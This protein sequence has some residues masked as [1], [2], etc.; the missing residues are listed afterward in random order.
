MPKLPA[1]DEVVESVVRAADDG[2]MPLEDLV[3]SFRRS[4]REPMRAIRRSI[5][6]GYLIERRGP[7]AR[8][9]VAVSSEGWR[10]RGRR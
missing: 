1:D 3:L 7:D 6:R 9:Y 8:R 2:F 5:R 10:L 4:R